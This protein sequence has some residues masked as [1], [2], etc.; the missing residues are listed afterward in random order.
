MGG[1]GGGA[2]MRVS[3]MP[4]PSIMPCIEHTHLRQSS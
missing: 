2:D 3:K 4:K 1:A